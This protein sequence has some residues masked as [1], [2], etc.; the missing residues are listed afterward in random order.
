L[1]QGLPQKKEIMEAAVEAGIKKEEVENI[2]NETAAAVKG[3]KKY[4]NLAG[5]TLS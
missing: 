1:G 5:N 2:L 3:L 4:I